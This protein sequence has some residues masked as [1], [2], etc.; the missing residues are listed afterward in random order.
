MF[1]NILVH[2]HSGLR[3]VVLLFLILAIIRAA[4]GMS[5]GKSYE[6]TGRKLAML[7]MIF[8]HLQIVIGLVL[9][10][11]SPNVQFGASTMSN[12][13]LRFFA[14]E[15]ISMMI[16]AAVVITAGYSRAKRIDDDR[17]S[18]RTVFWTYLISMLLILAS[19]PWPF[20]GFGNGWF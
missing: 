10:F 17:K 1:F 14:V 15:H 3:W 2:A 4:G 5:G 7:A 13:Q 20:R 18:F 8:V 19:I 6:A 11:I 16:V 12:P 9:Y